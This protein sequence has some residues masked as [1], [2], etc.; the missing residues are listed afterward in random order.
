MQ[1]ANFQMHLMPKTLHE[2]EKIEV[3]RV[4]ISSFT[5][6]EAKMNEIRINFAK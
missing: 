3:T 5:Q 4:L 1:R 6:K 2:T